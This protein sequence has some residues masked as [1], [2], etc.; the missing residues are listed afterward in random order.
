MMS[1]PTA[2]ISPWQTVRVMRFEATRDTLGCTAVPEAELLPT[3]T[4]LLASNRAARNVDRLAFIS[5]SCATDLQVMA[6]SENR[7]NNRID[8]MLARTAWA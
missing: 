2:K 3:G 6:T 8:F 7:E 5:G 4:A 1:D